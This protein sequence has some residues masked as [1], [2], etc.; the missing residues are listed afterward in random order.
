MEKATKQL[1][2]K[3]LGE[4]YRLQTNTQIPC[5]ASEGRIYGL[6][7]GVEEA[8]DSEL[9]RVGFIPAN[10]VLAMVEI[11]DAINL[12]EEKLANFKGYRQIEHLVHSNDISRGEASVILKYFKGEDM[13]TDIIEKMDTT[14]SPYELRTFELSEFDK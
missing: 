13:F 7:H 10:K 6:L 3:I 9:E 8:I 11:L 12:D 5:A 4:I 2:G 14:N 1:L